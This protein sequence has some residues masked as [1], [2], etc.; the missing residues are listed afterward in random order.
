MGTVNFK[1]VILMF[2]TLSVGAFTS[3]TAAA[4][5]DLDFAVTAPSQDQEDIIKSALRA[6]SNLRAA[7]NE[8]RTEAQDILAAALADYSAMT[9]ALYSE[10][11]YGGVVSILIDGQEASQ[12]PL[13]RAPNRISKV[14]INVQSG[15]KFKFSRAVID[16]LAR[17]TELPE[18][19]DRGNTARSTVISEAANAAISGWRDQGHA[20]ARI[21]QD[22]ATADHA[23]SRLSVEID[24]DQ[25][26]RVSFG[27]LVI[28]TPSAVRDNAIKRIAGFPKGEQFSPEEVEKV[29]ARLRRTRTFSSVVITEAETVAPDG[30]MDMLLEVSDQK[31]RRF[32]FGAEYSTQDGAA[33][34]AFWLHRNFYG[35]A[36][37]LRFD[38]AIS[39]ISTD[40]SGVDYSLSGRL[41]VPAIYGADTH[42]FTLISLEHLDEPTF[43]TDRAAITFGATRPLTDELTVETGIGFVKSRTKDDLGE[44]EFTL[45]TLPSSATVDKRSDPL[46]PRQGHYLSLQITPYLGLKDSQS[47]AR[48]YWDSRLYN[49]F[50]D[51]DPTVLATRLQLGSV[52]GSDIEGT[53]PEYLFH[54]GGG[55]TVRGQP[56][57]SLNIDLGSG[58]ETGGRSFAALSMELRQDITENLGL[59]AFADS[60][61]IGEGSEFDGSG[62]WHSGAGLGVRYQTGLGPIRFDVAGPTGGDTGD[63]VQFYLGIGQAF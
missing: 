62:E 1:S 5:D 36:E 10:G 60:G 47:G 57:Q 34:S 9:L 49:G 50:G 52:I 11:Y 44:R 30:S 12:I 42:G 2:A 61:Y 16:P 28:T 27:Q 48:V 14:Q 31:P 35:G 24:V 4:L 55:G 58:R 17:G 38:A 6:A 51:G 54:S 59:V 20:K 41:D 32:G 63:G 15:P 33:L 25:G 39:N 53:P 45:M 43:E 46:N 56:Y 3:T 22:R 13:L 29:L 37:R 18:G 21:A 7:E 40:A 19:F 23:N 8:D 26:P